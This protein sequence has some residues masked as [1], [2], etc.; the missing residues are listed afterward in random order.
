V[1][2]DAP[3]LMLAG[4]AE[5]VLPTRTVRLCDGGFCTFEGNLFT[6]IDNDFGGIESVEVFATGVGDEAPAGR[7]VFLPQSTAAAADLS[8]PS[9]QDSPFTFWTARVDEATGVVT[10]SRIEFTGRLDVTRLIIGR[11]TRKLE[12]DFVSEN[13]RLFARNKGNNLSPRFHKLINSGELGLDNAN[14]L[15]IAVPWGVDAPARGF[16]VVGGGGS[17]FGMRGTYALN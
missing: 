15:Q 7:L 5:F 11:G 9:F 6:S 13:E 4:L 17:D 8:Q 2:F 16:T 14:G 12:M 1:S 3:K 10:E